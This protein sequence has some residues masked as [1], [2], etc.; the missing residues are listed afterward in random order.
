[1][2]YKKNMRKRRKFNVEVSGNSVFITNTHT[3]TYRQY[4]IEEFI[5][6]Q[7]C[8]NE[9]TAK[10]PNYVHAEIWKKHKTC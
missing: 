10:Y 7:R 9:K 3:E 4:N 8:Y 1:M 6:G 2:D 5:H